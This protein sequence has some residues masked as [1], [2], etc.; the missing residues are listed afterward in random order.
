MPRRLAFLVAVCALLAPATAAARPYG[1]LATPTDQ[2]AVP[3]HVA[4]FEITP[5][6]FIYGGFGELVMRAGPNLV[7]VRAPVRT[8]YGGPYP[9]MRYG[10]K[11]AGVSYDIEAF[12]SIVSDQPV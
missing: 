3:G 6:G 10:Q 12:A 2:L 7:G 11:V 1:F 8:L 5:E 4:G 9:L